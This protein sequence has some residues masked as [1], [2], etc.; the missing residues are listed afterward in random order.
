MRLL[1]PQS[2]CS[3]I[4]LVVFNASL[5]EAHSTISRRHEDIR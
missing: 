2:Y 4:H 1:T 5:P 3:N